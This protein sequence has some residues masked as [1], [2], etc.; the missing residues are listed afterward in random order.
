MIL[1]INEVSAYKIYELKDS[2]NQVTIHFAGLASTKFSGKTENAKI[3]KFSTHKI[4]AR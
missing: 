1:Y 2:C 3:A 4:Y